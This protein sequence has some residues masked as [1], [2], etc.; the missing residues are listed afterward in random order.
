MRDAAELHEAFVRAKGHRGRPGPAAAL[1]Q[2][3]K[4]LLLMAA[5]SPENTVSSATQEEGATQNNMWDLY[6]IMLS[7]LNAKQ[8]LDKRQ[9]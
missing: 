8:K 4:E 6:A 7:A 9:K 3:R 2:R 1:S 5:S